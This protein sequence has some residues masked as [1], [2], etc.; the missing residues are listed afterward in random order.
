MNMRMLNRIGVLLTCLLFGGFGLYAPVDCY[1][2]VAA[3]PRE[4]RIVS[5]DHGAQDPAISPDGASIA[6]SI[7]G[8]IFV[9]PLAGGEARQ[10]TFG[11]SWDAHPAWSPD[12]QFLA[13]AQ[14]MATGTDLNVENLATGN[15][16]T[17]Y[18]TNSGL[19]QIAFHPKGG[20]I[21][22]LLDRSQYDSHLWRVPTAGGDAKQLTFTENW[23]EW[24]FALSPDGQQVL[25]DSGRYGGSN[26][27]R[28][29][30]EDLKVTRLTS[31]PNHQ[32]S[33]GWSRDG[34]TLAFVESDNGSDTVMLRPVDGGGPARRVASSPYDQ[35]QLALHPDGTTAVLCAGRRLYRLS[36][37][38]GRRT[39][40]PFV[41]RFALQA[42]SKPDLVITHARLFSGVGAESIPQATI[43]IRNGRVSR[44]S[45]GRET[46][47]VPA[48]V[49]VLDAAGKTVVPGLMDNHYHYW[50]PFD[51]ANLLTQGI[52]SIRDPG[53]A[54]STSLNFKEAIAL[55]IIA[56]PDIYTCGPLIDGPGGYH[57]Y[58]DVELS[59]PEAAKGLVRALKAQG[60]D[61]LK[62]YFQLAPDVLRAVVEEAHAQGLK[63]TG[64]IGVRTGWRE[65]MQS[66]IDGFNHIRVWKDFLPAEKQPQGE[67]ES[68]DAGKNPVA[69]MQADWS[70]IDP[71]GPGAGSLI[72]MMA[73]KKVGFDPTLS[74]QRVVDPQR[75]TFSLEQFAVARDAYQRM[76]QFV[77]RAYRKGVPILAGTDN[78][79]LF[80]EMEAYAEVGIP[81]ADVLRAASING[82]TWLGKG[83]DFGTIEVGKQADLLLIDGDPL[84]DIKDI[85]KISIVVKG[86]RIV[87]H[88]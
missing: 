70:E 66:G 13:Y 45:T 36:L 16:L 49:P 1:A 17:I 2:T 83:A 42:L 40:I 18:H 7:F 52:T 58:V 86:G 59:K 64:H 82:A 19:G 9:V 67:N 25:L 30:I 21:F 43:Y 75:R 50:T 8:K 78:G 26:L 33:V 79:S 35:K 77:V 31:T 81:A 27:Y 3:E 29:Q 65:A 53:T 73:E 38:S 68:L 41:A 10:I 51:G 22:F 56:G 47:A 28:I 84:K 37:D 57:P 55:G 12:G 4:A 61:A 34:N 71:M 6:V 20:E 44:I 23:H 69:R 62:V 32:F 72:D 87:F 54:V 48:G 24:S 85:R 88:K 15:A 60:V 76:G 11:P 46:D 5:V 14:Q 80:D 63:V 39:P 74:I